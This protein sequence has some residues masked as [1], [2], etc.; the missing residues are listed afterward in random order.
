[1]R[2]NWQQ[3]YDNANYYLTGALMYGCRSTIRKWKKKLAELEKEFKNENISTS[4][5]EDLV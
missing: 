1:M 5:Q 4:T 2:E 3:E